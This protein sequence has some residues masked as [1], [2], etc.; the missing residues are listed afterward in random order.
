MCGTDCF[1]GLQFSLRV[2]FLIVVA[3]VVVVVVV[4]VVAAAAVVVVVV[5]V[6]ILKFISASFRHHLR[7]DR[8]HIEFGLEKEGLSLVILPCSYFLEQ[9]FFSFFLFVKATGPF[10]FRGI[11]RA[12]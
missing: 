7:Y 2:R 8:N 10:L 12:Y 4:V 6:V 11:M 3:V 1:C 9:F 5:L